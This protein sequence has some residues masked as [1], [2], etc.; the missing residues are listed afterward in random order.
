MFYYS[1]IKLKKQKEKEKTFT[2]YDL[3]IFYETIQET[4]FYEKHFPDSVQTIC[5]FPLG[6]LSRFWLFENRIPFKPVLGGVGMRRWGGEARR[7]RGN[8]AA[9]KVILLHMK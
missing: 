6:T 8:H 5:L 9:P 3:G 1:F 2:H 7:G 4:V